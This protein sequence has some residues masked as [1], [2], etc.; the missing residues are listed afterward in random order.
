MNNEKLIKEYQEI[1]KSMTFEEIER[2]C[3]DT[4]LEDL[5]ETTILSMPKKAE[6][7]TLRVA[8]ISNIINSTDFEALDELDLNEL[9]MYLEEV[10]KGF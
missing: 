5:Y 2:L 1:L 3:K 10:K 7:E 9:I 8:L 6:I 4:S